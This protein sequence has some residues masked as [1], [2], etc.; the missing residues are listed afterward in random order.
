MK[1]IPYVKYTIE[2]R[3]PLYG[4]QAVLKAN[5]KS[6]K[7]WSIS[8]NTDFIGKV[9]DNKF[10]VRTAYGGRGL[11]V[12]LHGELRETEQGTRIEVRAKMPFQGMAGSALFWVAAPLSLCMGLRS[13]ELFHVVWGSMAMLIDSICLIWWHYHEKKARDTLYSRETTRKW[14]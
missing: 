4:V 5:M 7:E 8:G 9:Y 11:V 2:T 3:L 6:E 12:L 10:D 14:R 13:G 1:I